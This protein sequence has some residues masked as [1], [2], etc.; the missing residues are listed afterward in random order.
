MLVIL[1]SRGAFS[2]LGFAQPKG[3]EMKAMPS[4]LRPGRRSFSLAALA[5]TWML[6]AASSAQASTV[7]IGSPLTAVFESKAFCGPCT[8]TQTALPGAVVTSPSDGTI[9]RWRIKAASGPGGF[10]LRVLHPAG[11]EA[12]TGAGTSAEGKPVS[13]GTQ[14]FATDLPIHAGDL[15]GIDITDINE[16]IGEVETPSSKAALWV[17]PLADGSTLG[18][19]SPPFGPLEFAF[20]ADIQPLPGITSLSPSSGPVG[21]GTSVTITG[22]DFTGATAV[23]FGAVPAASFA[24]NS[25][26]QL[27]AISPPG[28]PGTVDVGVKNPGQS[29]TAGADAFTYTQTNIACVAPN[30]KHKTLKKAKKALTKAGCALGK[31]KGPKGKSAKVKKQNPKPG[32]VLPAGAK[33]NV[34]LA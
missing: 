31:V 19:N 6:I 24:V 32:K 33:V 4:M 26:T 11:F 18:P 27:T 12:E 22:H 7:T 9:V 34:K 23:S 2:R 15:I 16:K 25:D 10:K 3:F 29:P 28:A 1:A 30:L 5:A 14:V 8:V 13:F 20:N 17:P 21:G